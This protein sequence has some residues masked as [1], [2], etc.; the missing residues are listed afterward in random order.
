[1]LTCNVCRKFSLS[2]FITSLVRHA[3]I[4]FDYSESERKFTFPDELIQPVRMAEKTSDAVKQ[5]KYTRA[6]DVHHPSW[7]SNSHSRMSV[8]FPPQWLQGYVAV[9]L[10]N[11]AVVQLAYAVSGLIREWQQSYLSDRFQFVV[12]NEESSSRTRVSHGV[13]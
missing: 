1:M 5:T 13:S 11:Y 8:F 6:T 7:C 4:C 3:S 2:V 12:V 10:F 9:V